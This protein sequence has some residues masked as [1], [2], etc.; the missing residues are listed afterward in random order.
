MKAGRDFDV[1]IAKH[2]FGEKDTSGVVPKYSS[3]MKAAW[4]IVDLLKNKYPRFEISYSPTSVSF[5]WTVRMGGFLGISSTAP[6]A[7]C[8]CAAKALGVPL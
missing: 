3:D 6:Q 8:L 5:A 2:I 1:I 4:D 7:I